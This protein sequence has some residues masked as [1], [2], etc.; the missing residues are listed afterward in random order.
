MQ[1]DTK[2][3]LEK[4]LDFVNEKIYKKENMVSNWK[5]AYFTGIVGMGLGVLSL[6]QG[7]IAAGAIISVGSAI[8]K[9]M[10]DFS[11]VSFEMEKDDLEYGLKH[12]DSVMEFDLDDEEENDKGGKHFRK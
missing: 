10:N 11:L 7:R 5:A 2:R 1:E 12:P 6:H 3:K 9:A 4:R 8:F